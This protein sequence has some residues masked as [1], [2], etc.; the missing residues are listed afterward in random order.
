[1]ALNQR[2]VTIFELLARPAWAGGVAADFSP[3]RGIVGINRYG[4]FADAQTACGQWLRA[5]HFIFAGERIDMVGFHF[6]ELQ[7]LDGRRLVPA[8]L[9]MHEQGKL[10]Y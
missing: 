7:L 1:M 8:D 3:R 4:G 10:R 5:S 2:A 6:G 9:H